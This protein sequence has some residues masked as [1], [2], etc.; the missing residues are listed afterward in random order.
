MVELVDQLDA[1]GRHRHEQALAARAAS[2]Q[3]ELADAVRVVGGELDGAG[4]AHGVANEM[5]VLRTHRIEHAQHGGSV[6]RSAGVTR[7]QHDRVA[8]APAR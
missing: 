6:D 7:L 2:H 5:R 8:L 4:S 3:D 1:F